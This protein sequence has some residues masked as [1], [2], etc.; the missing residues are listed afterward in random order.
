M[1]FAPAKFFLF[2]VGRNSA[3]FAPRGARKLFAAQR[4]GCGSGAKWPEFRP[5]GGAKLSLG[6]ALFDGTLGLARSCPRRA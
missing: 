6:E 4:L 5:E 2:L 1:V 3:N